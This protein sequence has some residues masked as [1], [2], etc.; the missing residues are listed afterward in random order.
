MPINDNEDGYIAKPVP[1][2]LQLPDTGD[3]WE[4]TEDKL[5]IVKG[6]AESIDFIAKHAGGDSVADPHFRYFNMVRRNAEAITR[7][8]DE[9]LDN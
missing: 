3:W 5:F 2:A 1:P 7:L 4:S 8:V 9:I 6:L